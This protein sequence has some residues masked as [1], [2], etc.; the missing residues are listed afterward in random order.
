MMWW[1]IMDNSTLIF[2]GAIVL[3]VVGGSFFRYRESV[4]RDR[5][6]QT[7]AEK[8]QPIPPEL[9][10]GHYY[11]DRGS[12]GRRYYR[13][14]RAGRGV[15]LICIGIAL[16]VFLGGP[17]WNFDGSDFHVHHVAWVGIFPFMIG[18]A[19]LIVGIFERPLPP[20]PEK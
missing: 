18:V 17:D 10:T 6:I 16:F 12:Y 15:L 13:R 14:S 1:Q 8:G 2:W 20:P 11:S 3:I 19:Y 4:S 5:T 9:L 7:L